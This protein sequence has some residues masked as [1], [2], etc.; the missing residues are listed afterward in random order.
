MTKYKQISFTSALA[1]TA[2]YGCTSADYSDVT[3]Y[4][5]DHIMTVDPAQPDV[6]ALAVRNGMILGAG[7][8]VKLKRLYKGAALNTIFEGKTIVPGLIDPHVH[9]TLGSMMYALDFVP[10]WDMAHPTGI[11]KGLPD[12]DSFLAR[13]TE[14]EAVAP[15]GPLYL[16]GYHNLVQGDLTRQDLDAISTDRSIY[17]WHYSGHDFYLNS[18]AIENSKLDKSLADKYHGVGLDDDGELN[19]RIYEDAALALF[20]SIGPTLMSP[21]NLSRGFN[22]YE[23]IF[24]RGGITTV[25]EMGYGIFGRKLEDGVIAQFYG[26][27]DSYRLYLV[28]EKR[29]FAAEFGED[30]SAKILEM[31]GEERRAPVLPQVKFFTDAAFYSQTMRLQGPGY[32][33]GQS[34]G[35]N[36]LWVTQPDKLADDLRPY[37]NA[38]LDIHIHSNGDAAQDSTLNA[39]AEL[40]SERSEPEQRMVF[41]HVG[42][43]R[44]EQI[45]K[46]ADLGAGI[47]A[48][49]HYVHY[50]GDDYKSAIG[51]RVKFMSPLRSAINAGVPVTLHSD[52]PLAPPLPLVAAGVHMT[53]ATRHGTISTPSETI[54]AEQAL[55]AIT[56]D[57]AWSLGLEDEVG[58]IEVG[59]KADFTIL[60]QN[61]LEL[62]GE[63]WPRIDVWGVVL[64]GDLHPLKTP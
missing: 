27:D 56:L 11:I 25:A 37:W 2:I 63:D 53:R 10:P 8:E 39:L 50:M 24:A 26:D 44:P 38:G 55:R 14:L 6:E 34:K 21:G 4:T 23:K 57:A 59:K 60:G 36:G 48:A 5:A 15:D 54:T 22:G 49:S 51:D 18:A 20:A 62:K 13:V 46:A 17:I 32:I 31:T 64:G 35:T 12:R 7:P 28:P 1:F 47:S 16:Y 30:A 19:G 58:S 61:P 40:R 41:E 45:A 3:I 43:M 29:A 52:A 42:M 33:G 9:M